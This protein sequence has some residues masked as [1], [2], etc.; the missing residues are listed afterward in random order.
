ML[1]R[2]CLIPILILAS[3]MVPVPANAATQVSGVITTDTTWTKANSPYEV[4]G[5]LGIDTGATLTIESGVSVVLK[6]SYKIQVAGRVLANGTT[7]DR[8]YIGCPSSTNC[9]QGIEFVDGQN[10]SVLNNIDLSGSSG[11]AALD[12]SDGTWTLSNSRIHHN[13][14][15]IAAIW[16][17]SGNLTHNYI[18]HNTVGVNAFFAMTD[19]SLNTITENQTGFTTLGSGDALHNNNIFGNSVYNVDVCFFSGASNV[20][21]ATGNWWGSTDT[22][23]IS[24]KICDHSDDLAKPT[25]NYQPFATAPVPGAA[26]LPGVPLTVTKAGDGSGS[27]TSTPA[28]IDCGTTCSKSFPISSSVTLVAEPEE[29]SMFAGWS[30]ACSGTGNCVLQ[31]SEPR[32]VVATFEPFRPT[33]TPEFRRMWAHEVTEKGG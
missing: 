33:L 7:D 5:N 32:S 3:L 23:Q 30:G 26:E 15:S 9:W 20:V 22:T 16:G 14:P 6:G 12:A 24:S 1:R 2:A 4:V 29:G 10:G 25:V 31:M 18:D 11:M 19:F 27:V 8:I 21:D 28:G 13:S 17:S